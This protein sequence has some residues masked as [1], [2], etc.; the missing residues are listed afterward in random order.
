MQQCNFIGNINYKS[1]KD[2]SYLMG[3]GRDLE[4]QYLS[5]IGMFV[6]N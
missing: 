3:N 5:Q 1:N 6:Y 4:M 2:L